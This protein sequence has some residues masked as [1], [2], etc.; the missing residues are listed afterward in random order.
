M[1]VTVAGLLIPPGPVQV[2]EYV[3][4]DVRVLVLCA[5]LADF[6]PLQLPEAAQDVAF[7]ELQVSTAALPATTAFGLATRVAVGTTLTVALATLLAPPGP[8]QVSE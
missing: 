3:V 7:E 5:P 6:V 1:T 4:L 8:E 2:S